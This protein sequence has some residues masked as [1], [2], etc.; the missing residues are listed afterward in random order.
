M[1]RSEPRE[2]PAGDRP[3][4]HERDR[5]QRRLAAR[6]GEAF[7]HWLVMWGAYSRQFWAFPRFRAPRGTIA[8]A[9]DP[10]DLAAHMREV[11]AASTGRSR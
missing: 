6:I 9:A 3:L 2:R 1:V 10:G 5:D 11:Q 4:A 8:H 7:P